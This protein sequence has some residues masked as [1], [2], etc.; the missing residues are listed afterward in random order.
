MLSDLHILVVED[1]PDIRCLLDWVL[2]RSG[3]TVLPVEDGVQALSSVA[4]HPEIDMV[5]MDMR[6]PELDGYETTRQLRAAGFS[7]PIL[8]LTALAMAG[9]REKCLAAGCDEYMS[10]PLFSEDVVAW[11]MSV[12]KAKA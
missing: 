4:H 1:S 3:A 10:K 11:C 7:K 5:I 6:M 9:D 12:R 8:A 2:S